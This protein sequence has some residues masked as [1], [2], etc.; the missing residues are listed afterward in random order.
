MRDV[1]LVEHIQKG[2]LESAISNVAFVTD[3]FTLAIWGYTT[4]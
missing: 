4:T 2:A 1:T 3:V